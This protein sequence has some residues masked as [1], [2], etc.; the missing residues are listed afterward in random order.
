MLLNT[1][2]FGIRGLTSCDPCSKPAPLRGNALFFS[3]FDDGSHS[4]HRLGLFVPTSIAQ[5]STPLPLRAATR[6]VATR[7]RHRSFYPRLTGR[8]S[9]PQSCSRASVSACGRSG[10][11]SRGYPRSGITS[12]P[13]NVVVIRNGVLRLRD[14]EWVTLFFLWPDV[15][16]VLRALFA[17]SSLSFAIQSINALANGSFIL[18]AT[19]RVSSA[20]LRQCL[21]SIA[22][23]AGNY[24]PL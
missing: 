3:G 9:R 5:A 15:R 22:T 8:D 19:L 10:W 21:G 14:A 16:P 4:K 12:P 20:R 7:Q 18:S 17:T 24:E 1:V 11:P 13:S 6:C 23:D 2:A